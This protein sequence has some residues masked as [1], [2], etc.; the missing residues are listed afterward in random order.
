[1]TTDLLTASRGHPTTILKLIL[2]LPEEIGIR[3]EAVGD[4][5]QQYVN[6]DFDKAARWLNTQERGPLHDEAI[7]V[8]VRE[9]TKND[10]DTA[11]RWAEEIFD[12]KLRAETIR[13]VRDR[14][15]E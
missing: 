7:E 3:R 4:A 13:Y 8:F 14:G 5:F 11:M 6:Q 9:A 12:P 1:M 15:G 2:E 10:T